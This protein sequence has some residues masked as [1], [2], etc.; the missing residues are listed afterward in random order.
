MPTKPELTL[1]LDDATRKKLRW[2]REHQQWTSDAMVVRHAIDHLYTACQAP[3]AEK[4]PHAAYVYHSN[5]SPDDF[6]V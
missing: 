5:L 6:E 3:Q 2:L 4:S 1:S